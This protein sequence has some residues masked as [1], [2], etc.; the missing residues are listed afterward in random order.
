MAQLIMVKVTLFM[1]SF[2]FWPLTSQTMPT[3]SFDSDRSVCVC[4]YVYKFFFFQLF[5]MGSTSVTACN[6]MY[7]GPKAN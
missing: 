4:T 5:G 2:Y 6:L 3:T 7:L 1:Y